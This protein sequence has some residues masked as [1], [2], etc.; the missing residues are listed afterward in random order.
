MICITVRERK[1]NTLKKVTMKFGIK[2]SHKMPNMQRFHKI[3]RITI[4]IYMVYL[5]NYDKILTLQVDSKG[6][7]KIMTV[8]KLEKVR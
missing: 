7:H 2:Y 1:K 5:S 3:N 8:K 6:Q 4:Y